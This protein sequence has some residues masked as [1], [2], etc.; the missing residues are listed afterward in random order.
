MSITQL[1]LL[2]REE[3]LRHDEVQLIL[4]SGTGHRHRPPSIRGPQALTSTR[5][6]I[7]AG[8]YLDIRRR[9]YDRTDR[10]FQRPDR[11]PASFPP[12]TATSHRNREHFGAAWLPYMT[13]TGGAAPSP[14][15]HTTGNCL[16]GPARATSQN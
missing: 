4:G 7:V 9:G 3:P 15:P 6:S 14:I 10:R 1:G 12:S 13:G 11:H 8:W 5:C 2:M 16:P